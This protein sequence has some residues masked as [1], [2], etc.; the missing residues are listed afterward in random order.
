MARAFAR[1]VW[2]VEDIKELKP[3]W[4][5]QECEEWLEDNEFDIRDRIVDAGWDIIRA[6]LGE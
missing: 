4:S 6:L 5:K 2:R 3:D 1:V